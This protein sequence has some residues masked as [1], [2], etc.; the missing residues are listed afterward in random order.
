MRRSPLFIEIAIF[1]HYSPHP[2]PQEDMHEAQKEVHLDLMAYGMI[3]LQDGEY[4]GVPA[5]LSVY[6]EA[7][8]DVPL[9]VN[10]WV[11]PDGR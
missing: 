10:K 3:V 7:L 2:W 11:I 6:V 4:R 8:G 1:Y 5:A 9:P